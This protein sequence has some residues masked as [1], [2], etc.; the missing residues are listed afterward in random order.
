M[1][2]GF[3]TSVV[4]W[5]HVGSALF[6]GNGYGFTVLGMRYRVLGLRYA[7]SDKWKMIRHPVCGNIVNDIR[8]FRNRARTTEI[9]T[10]NSTS[11]SNA[12]NGRVLNF[13]PSYIH[14]RDS[15]EPN[16]IP[17]PKY[18]IPNTVYLIPTSIPN[19][20]VHLTMPF[21]RNFTYWIDK[22]KCRR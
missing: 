20:I 21:Q 4:G 10:S 16:Y 8:Y 15:T 13:L 14:A 3:L 9:Y 17:L 12:G 6:A 11:F 22:R 7:E 19:P 1:R 2:F 18:L 5:S